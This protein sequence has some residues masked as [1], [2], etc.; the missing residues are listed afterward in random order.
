[1][2]E[3]A[4]LTSLEEAVREVV[5]GQDPAGE[6]A[7]AHQIEEAVEEVRRFRYA[8]GP[9]IDQAAAV[10]QQL[11]RD[12]DIQDLRPLRIRS[13]G[14]LS[15]EA[16]ELGTRLQQL[17]AVAALGSTA[18]A[19]GCKGMG[20]L[21]ANVEAGL[22]VGGQAGAELVWLWPYHIGTYKT[23]NRVVGRAWYT[24]TVGLDLGY[25]LTL[26]PFPLDLSFWF[27]PPENT[28]H[29]VGAFLGYEGPPLGPLPVPIPLPLF[30]G[31]RVELFGWVPT[32]STLEAG[33][34]AG[35]S[36]VIT[37]AFKYIS[38]FRIV[39]EAGLHLAIGITRKGH[40]VT[41]AGGIDLATYS[42]SPSNLQS[43]VR[44]TG[45]A[46]AQ[47]LLS[48][49]ISAPQRDDLP[50]K[51]F[52][53]GST[54]LK[55][56]FPKWMCTG[57]S[58]APALT[59]ANDGSGG[60]TNWQLT[61]QPSITDPTYEYQWAGDDSQPWQAGISFTIAAY[62][63]TAPPQTGKT[64]FEM[65]GLVSVGTV[66]VPISGDICAMKLSAQ[67][68][69]ATGTYTL[70]VDPTK[71]TIEDYQGNT[72]T[73]NMTADDSGAGPNPNNFYYLPNPNNS[74]EQLI[75]DY[76]D[77]STKWYVGYQFQQQAGTSNAQFR[78][79]F[80][81]VGKP[82]VQLFYYAGDW[83]S[84]PDSSPHTSS[85]TWSGGSITSGTTL[86]ITLTASAAS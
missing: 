50:S 73:T 29:M 86:S 53:Q 52:Q 26:V 3:S 49:A 80:W 40:Q 20:F 41:T 18:A 4:L 42:L 58:T 82:F 48:G 61:N 21:T 14:Q 25:S 67:V 2:P 16:L 76:P 35:P 33:P 75:I 7:W 64:A 10:Q 77:K 72:V 30:G 46:N 9:L 34:P 28:N 5:S 60:T 84:L 36:S 12:P 27:L 63:N 69:A 65:K 74:S 56:S 68:F 24:E 83:V 13:D 23:P 6:P 59:F 39:A 43:G 79:V 1:V 54:T 8:I 78:P 11:H 70:T 85:V 22:L 45:S 66:N 37:D 55:L 47:P 31:V 17:P 15:V 62:S 32:T 51:T 57:M 38:G 81:E 71:N 19:Q 44:Y